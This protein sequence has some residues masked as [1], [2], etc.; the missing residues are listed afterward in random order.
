MTSLNQHWHQCHACF[1]SAVGSWQLA[2]LT[3]VAEKPQ[4]RPV[5][6]LPG[7][8]TNS[9]F[10]VKKSL[11][12]IGGQ[13]NY[14]LSREK[15]FSSIPL[16]NSLVSV[17]EPWRAFWADMAPFKGPRFASSVASVTT[18]KQGHCQVCYARHRGCKT[19]SRT[20]DVNFDCMFVESAL[21]FTDPWW[22][23]VNRKEL[24]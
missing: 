7:L 18:E 13:I 9:I 16:S 20:A 2:W 17:S 5:Y 10:F 1:P 22:W 19:P 23:K 15:L 12:C 8:V 3:K 4:V 24:S 6:C 21:L 14:P 11:F